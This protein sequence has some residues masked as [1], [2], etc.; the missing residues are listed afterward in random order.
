MKKLLLAV[1]IFVGVLFIFSGL[2]KANDPHG[3]GYKMQEFFEVWNEG[4]AGSSFFLKGFFISVFDFFHE[5]A[6]LL[7]VIMIALE[8][9]AGFAVII[10]WQ[11][12][13]FSWLLLL[14]IVF[15]TFLTGY[16][17]LATKAD[18]SPKFTN[19]G[20]F[21]DCLPITP[22]ISFTKDVILTVLILLLFFFR[23]KIVSALSNRTGLLAMLTVTVLSFGI[24][25][26]T[27]SYL[28]VLD[29]LPFKK[30]N[31]ISEQMKMPANAIPDSMVITYVYEKG[32][33]QVE[34]TADKLPADLN[35]YKYI[36]RD[37]KLIRKGK[38]NVPPIKGFTLTGTGDTD[39]A[40]IVLS[41]PYA[42]LL[43]AEDFST[44]VKEWSSRFSAI[45]KIAKQ[46]NIPLYMV[47]TKY[48]EAVAA[49]ATTAFSQIQIFKCDVTNVRTAARSNPCLF[50]LQKGTIE[51]KWSARQFGKA[52]DV[53]E[54]IPTQPV[55][56]IIEPEL[57]ITPGVNTADTINK[58]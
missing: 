48:S 30:G 45:Y 11:M 14:M 38:N 21:G 13:F 9:I 39:S 1:R 56:E 29:C 40:Q 20:C 5:H 42:I 50:I 51:G 41:K 37:D 28:P 46:K 25:W 53:L 6:L 35:T 2:I 49:L 19:C 12:R 18:G 34:F 4:L 16:A 52:E 27:L 58:N 24:Q 31:N 26:Y 7:A 43:F 55:E 10:G 44:P 47:T 54:K 17:W 32:G 23:K 22:D 15:F 33:T 57:E 36:K 3:L 8:I